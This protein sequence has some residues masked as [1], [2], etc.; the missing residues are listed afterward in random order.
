MVGSP[1]ITGRTAIGVAPLALRVGGITSGGHR[2][3]TTGHDGERE[4]QSRS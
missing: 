2:C 3:A 1:G 4:Q